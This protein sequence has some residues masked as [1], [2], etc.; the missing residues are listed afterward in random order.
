MH[1]DIFQLSVFEIYHL[2]ANLRRELY[3]KL[4]KIS[5]G[6][7][8]CLTLGAHGTCDHIRY[9]LRVSLLV[10]GPKIDFTPSNMRIT[11]KRTPRM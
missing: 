11:L 2:L 3:L 5:C 7:V 9:R 8:D 6:Q 4:E 1:F 10:Y